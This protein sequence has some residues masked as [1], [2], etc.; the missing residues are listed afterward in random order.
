MQQRCRWGIVGTG[1]IARIMAG[2]L[3]DSSTGH[4]VAVASRS[5]HRA[6]HFAAEFEVTRH[7][8]SYESLIA[9]PEV[10]IVYVA[11]HHP[12]H[13]ACAVA[14]A[15]AGKHVL[16]E[17]PLAMNARG[18]AEI[19][20]AARRNGTF[21]MEAFAYRCHPQTSRLVDIL[22]SGDI[23]EV[24]IIDAAFGY[25]AGVAPDNYLLARELGG[26]GILDVGC[27][28]TSMAHL[29]A[30]TASGD[31][32]ASCADVAGAAHIG[33][34]TGVDHYAAAVLKFAGQAIARVACAIQVDLDSTLRIYGTSGTLTVSSPWLPGRYGPPPAILVHRRG[35]APA[36][37]LAGVDADVYVLEADA[38]GQLVLEGARSHPLMSWDESV[39][40]MKTLD[41]WREAIGLVYKQDEV[42]PAVGE[43]ATGIS[44][45]GRA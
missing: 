29:I 30:A 39:A 32:V 13:L 18:G 34:S 40:N 41:R 24:R 14:A 4:L 28:A 22:A 43:G 20:E 25:D 37:V 21:L 9:D 33:S 26:G 15:D 6:R 36:E 35:S 12:D 23:G 45:P 2:A 44:V 19:I 5:E 17:K 16:C 8:A 11:S 31:D 1:K 10:D 7:H 27:Y 3:R 42:Q 38:V